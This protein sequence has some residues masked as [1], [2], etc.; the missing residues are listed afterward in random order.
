MEELLAFPGNGVTLWIVFI[1]SIGIAIAI[2]MGLID[3]LRK[4]LGKQTEKLEMTADK[5]SD[6]FK[7]ALLW[8]MIWIGLASMFAILILL[9]MGYDKMIEFVTGYT[10]EKSLS[11][12]N[13]FVFVLIFSTLAI[14]YQY[15][16]K[17]LTFGILSAIAMRIPLI[18]VGVSILENF[19][20]IV[21]FFGGLLVFT[22]VRMMLQ[23]EE[24]KIE[25][26]KSIL[27]R[28]IMPITTELEGDK[29]FTKKNGIVF[30]TPILVALAM[31]ES[32]DL[33]F[34]IDSIPAVLAI[35]SDPFIVIT[36]NLFAILGLRN[37]YLLLAGRIEKFYYL[38]PALVTLLLFVGFKMI[39][40]DFVKL[41]TQ[42]SLLVIACILLSAVG[43]SYIKTR[44]KEKD[45]IEVVEN[46]VIT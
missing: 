36:S 4:I 24:K 3:K 1:L 30:A 40:V 27:L 8:T 15:Q 5:D 23:K 10:L 44:Q 43:L 13:M 11:V 42:I 31:I 17:V 20:W 22:A 6:P 21:Y 25:V 34:A 37:L 29:F 39:A 2:D 16:H 38:R 33:V 28:K 14:P 9:N 19:R 12:D 18:L 26:E 35:T 32:A 45:R 46:L 7:R 41:P